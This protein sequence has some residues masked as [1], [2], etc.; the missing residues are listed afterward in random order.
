MTE[1]AIYIVLAV[2]LIGIAVYD[3]SFIGLNTLRDIL[4]QSSTRVI[5]ALGVAFILITG[6]R[7]C[8]PAGWSV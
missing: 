5:I 6:G 7:T 2:L 4:I 8:P 3:P 1:N